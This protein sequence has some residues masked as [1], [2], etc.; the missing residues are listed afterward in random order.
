MTAKRHGRTVTAFVVACLNVTF[1]QSW[2]GPGIDMKG[3]TAVRG[4]FVF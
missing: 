2:I 1:I 3:V 4:R